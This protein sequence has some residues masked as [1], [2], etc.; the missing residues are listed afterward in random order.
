MIRK[1]RLKKR[2]LKMCRCCGV[3]KP[4]SEFH[5]YTGAT[6]RSPDGRRAICKVCRN[7]QAREYARRKRAGKGVA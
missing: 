4:L 3:E 1:V 5:K 6:C 7:E 2:I